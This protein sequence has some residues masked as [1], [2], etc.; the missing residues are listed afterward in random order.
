M[1]GS[2]ESHN[3]GL[4]G[5]QDASV[6]LGVER[7]LKGRPWRMRLDAA[8]EAAALAISQAHGLSDTVARVLAGRGISQ[9][10]AAAFLAPSLK[11]DMPDPASLRDMDKAVD[12]LA[13]AV[14]RGEK[15]AIFGDYDVDGATSSA[16]LFETL[17]GLGLSPEIYIPDRL[18]EG[19]GPNPEAIDRLVDGG[20][21]LIVTVDCGATSFEALQRAQ[22]RGVDVVVIDHHQM[23]AELPPSVALVNPNRQDD[24]SGLTNLAAV[25]LV[26]M[27]S[28]ALLRELRRRGDRRAAP[29]LLR[30]LDLVALGTVCD[31]VPLTG[32]NRAFVAKGLISLRH[33]G[34]P[35]L[36][37]L[38]AAARLTGPVETGH[39]GFLLGPRINA[40]GRIGEA[41]LGARLLTTG[42]AAEAERIAATLE[43][44]N[45]ERQAIEA[46]AVAEAAADTEAAI[47]RRGATPPLVLAVGETWHPGVVGLVA[48][49][50]KERFGRPAFAVTF[51]GPGADGTGSG[52]SIP[53]VDLG[54]AVRAAV[55]EGILKKGGG[56]HMAAGI[57]VERG[58]LADFSA[59][60][61]ARLAGAVEKALAEDFLKLD[62]LVTA[63][64]AS[65]ELFAELEKCGPYGAGHAS[66][67][68]ALPA[69]RI[70][71]ADVVGT[72]HVKLDLRSASGGRIKAMAFREAESPLGQALLKG[73]GEPMHVAGTLTLNRWG[74]QEKVEL[75]VLDAAPA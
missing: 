16:L 23:G 11:T 41:G 52:R 32:L 62:A 64:G 33:G 1:W 25:G 72:S 34:R 73:R 24:I 43:R 53:G 9:D 55:A 17:S 45:A 69:H 12:R 19:Y 66:P 67:V 63:E 2:S 60:L 65:R 38:A 15:V 54:A 46:E 56:H 58:R 7:S 30:A 31:V 13:D 47:A 57:T 29:D 21:Q 27:T 39:C 35:G 59:F 10:R 68:V 70:A 36:V 75:R 22:E 8:G 26:F 74:G 51:D 44:L 14:Q 61:E 71:Y 20:A 28:V 48:A 4:A 3:P 40:G 37:A 18:I 6:S 42:D 5:G 50:L 49:R